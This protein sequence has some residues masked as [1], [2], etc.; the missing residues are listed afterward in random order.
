MTSTRWG[1]TQEIYDFNTICHS[2]DENKK[3]GTEFLKRNPV[4]RIYPG[5]TMLPEILSTAAHE[6]NIS[7]KT[8][9]SIKICCS[10]FFFSNIYR[11]TWCLSLHK[12]KTVSF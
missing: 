9:V 3:P 12:L 6:T 11:K 2:I 8:E 10:L 5:F 7:M 4:S 1:T